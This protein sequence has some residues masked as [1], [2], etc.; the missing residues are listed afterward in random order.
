MIILNL[1]CRFS[2]NTPKPE[3]QTGG[4]AMHQGKSGELFMA[5]YNNLQ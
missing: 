4:N 5:I 2:Q 1:T 3:A